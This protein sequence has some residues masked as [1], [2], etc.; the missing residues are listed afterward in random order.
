MP[1]PAE[2]GLKEAGEKGGYRSKGVS[3]SLEEGV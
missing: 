3:R 2:N 1:G